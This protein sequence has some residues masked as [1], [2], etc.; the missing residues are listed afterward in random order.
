[1][2]DVCS[3]P[4]FNK[5][6]FICAKSLFDV[7]FCTTYITK[8]LYKKS[9]IIHDKNYCLDCLCA[10][11]GGGAKPLIARVLAYHSK[12]FGGVHD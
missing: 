7:A 2:M 8:L 4:Q 12:L 1:M 9:Q 5:I 11:G 3:K 6:D 10:L